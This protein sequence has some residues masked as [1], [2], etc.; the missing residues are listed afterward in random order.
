[1]N[2]GAFYMISY[3]ARDMQQKEVKGM[4]VRQAGCL[5]EARRNV[6]DILRD[7]GLH[8]ID[9]NSCELAP[10]GAETVAA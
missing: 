4:M 9:I 5:G 10:F 7:D 1:M 3:T 6:Y 2:K 8:S